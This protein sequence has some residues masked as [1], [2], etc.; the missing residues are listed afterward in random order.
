LPP[1]VI[2]NLV[3][4][5]GTFSVTVTDVEAPMPSEPSL[6]GTAGLAR[7]TVP[8]PE[9]VRKVIWLTLTTWLL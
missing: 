1:S 9:S 3:T 2:E 8:D 4:V 5:D 6:A 7:V